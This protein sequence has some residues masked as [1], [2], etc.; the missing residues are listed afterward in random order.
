MHQSSS[1]LHHHATPSRNPY[2]HHGP[3]MAPS[4]LFLSSCIL[5]S[6]HPAPSSSATT[7]GTTCTSELHGCPILLPVLFLPL[8]VPT[9]PQRCICRPPSASTA[10]PIILTHPAH[11]IIGTPQRK[12]LCKV[13]LVM[14]L[15]ILQLSYCWHGRP[16]DCV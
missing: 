5:F 12:I 16:H 2:C 11:L 9:P 15:D 8:I 1:R 10:A 6:L 14:L 3:R 13:I 7:P 4:G